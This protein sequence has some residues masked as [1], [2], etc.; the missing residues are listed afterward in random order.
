MGFVKCS[1]VGNEA[2]NVLFF[3]YCGIDRLEKNI[4]VEKSALHNFII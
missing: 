2:T 3:Q 4:L 1:R